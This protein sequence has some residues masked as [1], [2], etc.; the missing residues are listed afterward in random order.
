MWG[1]AVEAASVTTGTLIPI[2]PL[3]PLSLLSICAYHATAAS[4]ITAQT[5]DGLKYPLYRDTSN[6]F[7]MLKIS[8][9]SNPA[10]VV[11]GIDSRDTVGDVYGR[12][13][14]KPLAAAL[15]I[16]IGV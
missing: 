6:K 4:A 8:T 1:I 5:S 11:Y 16:N 13:L 12:Y 3:T 7:H 9:Q 10:F 14:V 2:I 15:Q